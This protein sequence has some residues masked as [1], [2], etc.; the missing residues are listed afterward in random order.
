MANSIIITLTDI[1][2][3]T[4][5][6]SNKAKYVNISI[7]PF[8]GIRVAVPTGVS[9]ESARRIAETK[10]GWMKAQLYNNKSLEREYN[11]FIRHEAPMDNYDA[12]TKIVNRLKELSKKHKI[13]YNKVFIIPF[14]IQ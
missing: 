10:S 14:L 5:E 7:R 1:G 13:P 11:E 4:F 12:K 9:M 8:N 6:R 2:E 3:V